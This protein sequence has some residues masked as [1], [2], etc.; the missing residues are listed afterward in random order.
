MADR[1]GDYIV[2]TA[3]ET[4]ETEKLITEFQQV[5]MQDVYDNDTPVYQVVNNLQE[6]IQSKG[7]QMNRVEME[8]VYS[9]SSV[10][11]QNVT[12][13][14]MSK[15]VQAGSSNVASV[16]T[17]NDPGLFTRTL[18][19][20]LSRLVNLGSKPNTIWEVITRRECLVP[21]RWLGIGNTPRVTVVALFIPFPQ[22]HRA[23]P[24]LSRLHLHRLLCGD[25]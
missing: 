20:T 17:V 8:D 25:Q 13:W 14:L 19:F 11:E 2:G 6:Q 5:I 12:T 1:I 24:Q 15:N 3:L 18:I 7:I 9:P 22:C 10:A 4:I 21:L 16:S 23:Y